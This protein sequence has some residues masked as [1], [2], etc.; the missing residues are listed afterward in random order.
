MP[1]E[2]LYRLIRL[3]VWFENYCIREIFGCGGDSQDSS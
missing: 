3:K 1:V 2:C